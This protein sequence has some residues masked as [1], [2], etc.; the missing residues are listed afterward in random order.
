MEEFS[1]DVEERKIQTEGGRDQCCSEASPSMSSYVTSHLLCIPPSLLALLSVL[2]PH[3]SL[4]WLQPPQQ[5]AAPHL[6]S[7]ECLLLPRT[8]RTCYDCN[9]NKWTLQ[10]WKNQLHDSTIFCF[11]PSIS[12]CLADWIKLISIFFVIWRIFRRWTIQ[13]TV[14]ITVSPFCGSLLEKQDA[15]FLCPL[16]PSPPLNHFFELSTNPFRG[17]KNAWP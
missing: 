4:H 16:V 6:P 12:E 2:S 5:A 8:I 11:K 13:T 1:K 9:R 7:S 3:P 10:V 17:D 15:I 14:F